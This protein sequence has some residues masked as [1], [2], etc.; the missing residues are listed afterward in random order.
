M[1]EGHKGSLVCSQCLTLAFDELW[2][3]GGGERPEKV[4]A[5]APAQAVAAATCVM[6]LEQRDE[7]YWHSPAHPESGICKRCTKQAVV[8]LERDPDA[9]WKRPGA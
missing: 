4:A 7:P 8:M 3:R 1:V 9:E 6:C 2:N 5:D